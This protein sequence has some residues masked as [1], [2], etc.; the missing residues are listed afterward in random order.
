MEISE[1]QQLHSEVLE[2]TILKK[3]SDNKLCLSGQ[4]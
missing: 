3:S 4:N 2:I 1:L